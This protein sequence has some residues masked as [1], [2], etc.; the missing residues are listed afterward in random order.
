MDLAC[1][2]MIDGAVISPCNVVRDLHGIID[3]YSQLKFHDQTTTTIL[4]KS[5]ISWQ[6]ELFRKLFNTLTKILYSYK[7]YIWP[8]LENVFGS[9]IICE[10]T[11]N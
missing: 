6:L 9:T 4:R 2:Y 10:N 3:K 8:V 1:K 11:E 7:T 5:T